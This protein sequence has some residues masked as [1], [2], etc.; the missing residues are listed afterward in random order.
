MKIMRK[1]YFFLPVFI[2][3]SFIS[4]AQV[5]IINE[6]FNGGL[7]DFTA[8]GFNI[9]AGY[10]ESFLTTSDTNLLVTP[11]MNLNN[12]TSITLTF[13]VYSFNVTGDPT[14]S[15]FVDVSI[16]GGNSWIVGVAT[17][18]LLNGWQAGISVDLSSYDNQ[19]VFVRFKHIYALATPSIL[20]VDNVV[21][22]GEISSDDDIAILAFDNLP[23]GCGLTNETISIEVQNVGNNPITE[24]SASYTLNGATVN[25]IFTTNL[26][27]GSPAQVFSFTDLAD[28]SNAGEYSISANVSLTG[29]LNT[30]N[31]NLANTS[32]TSYDAFDS[33][34]ES[35]N[36]EAG[37]T[38]P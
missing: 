29:D 37:E 13:D 31:D 9:S 22:S 18:N 7:N 17:L 32:L 11:E 38:F 19:N 35:E 16:D 4:S 5:Q 1:F 10:V 36:F 24:F 33:F 23:D 28:L 3:L 30:T 6:D 8:D 12:Y 2:I 14:N 27:F 26:A 25:E 15:G 21:I 20:R 34:P